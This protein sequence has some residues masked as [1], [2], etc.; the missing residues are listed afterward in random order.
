MDGREGSQKGRKQ[1]LDFGIRGFF[2]GVGGMK[3]TRFCSPCQRETRHRRS[4]PEGV[5][6]YPGGWAWILSAPAVWIA[7][8]I[9]DLVANR[10]HCIERANRR[11]Y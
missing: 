3:T 6:P 1:T 8:L 10:W 5:F 11:D 2:D 9:V 7:N 4:D